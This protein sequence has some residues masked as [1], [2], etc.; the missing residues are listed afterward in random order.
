MTAEQKALVLALAE[1][2]KDADGTINGITQTTKGNRVVN[3]DDYPLLKLVRDAINDV[4]SEKKR[5]EEKVDEQES[6]TNQNSTAQKQ[7]TKN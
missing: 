3:E 2:D 7:K 1:L 5:L 4:P 6:E